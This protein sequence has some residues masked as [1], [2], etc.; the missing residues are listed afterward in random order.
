MKTEKREAKIAR[1][2]EVAWTFRLH[3]D[4]CSDRNIHC[5]LYRQCLD[6]AVQADWSDWTCALCPLASDQTTKPKA[7]DFAKRQRPDVGV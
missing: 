2:T 5:A 3:E 4:A 6:V 1:P 7:T